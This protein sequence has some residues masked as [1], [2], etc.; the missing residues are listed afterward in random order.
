M[1][2]LYRQRTPTAAPSLAHPFREFAG[3]IDPELTAIVLPCCCHFTRVL[4]QMGW[5]PPVSCRAIRSAVG[6]YPTISSPRRRGHR[7][8]DTQ[9][10][11][12]LPVRAKLPVLSNLSYRLVRPLCRGL[13]PGSPFLSL[14]YPT[15][16]RDMRGISAC[17][18]PRRDLN[19]RPPTIVAVAIQRQRIPDGATT[20]ANPAPSFRCPALA[21]H[22]SP[23]A[24]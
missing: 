3:R 4:P 16:L 8:P 21:C 6:R 24:P 2:W 11:F 7:M 9:A 12:L 14:L 10:L 23:H 19:P 18:I 20:T 13:I 17:L 15:E 22:H 1:A 5:S